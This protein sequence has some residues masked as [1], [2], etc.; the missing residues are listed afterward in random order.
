MTGLTITICGCGNGAHA[1]AA[2]MSLKGHRVNVFSPLEDEI[3]S[4][5][6]AYS[7]NGGLT[8][9]FG[10]GLLSGLDALDEGALA[11]IETY[12][13]LRL[14]KIS[15]NP[16]E[17]IPQASLI[18]VIVPAFAHKNILKSIAPHLSRDSLLVFLPSRGGLELELKSIVPEARVMAFQTL[19]W[20]TR[21][22]KFG[23]EILISARKNSILA[24]ARPMDLSELFFAQLEHLLDMEI[25]PVKH[26]ATLTFSNI[27]QI[28]HPGIMYSIFK[29]NPTER[30]AADKLPFFYQ[31]IDEE[32]GNRLSCMSEELIKIAGVAG[33]INSDIETN[34]VLH[35][36]DWL[37]TS[38][39]GLIADES[40]VCRMIV[41][42]KAYDGLRAPV[43][44]L[45]DGLYTPD[46]GTRYITED[47]P[48]GLL[49]SKS[50]AIMGGVDT[51][52]IDEVLSGIDRWTGLDYL[53]RLNVLKSI[54]ASSRL[55]ELYGIDTLEDLLNGG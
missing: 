10:A 49:I 34:R 43:R 39:E 50:I 19:P 32:G 48:Y 2:L 37:K 53:G 51:P 11:Q 15:S 17:V 52:T 7:E 24:A 47:V 8:M 44:K 26:M 55:P 31:A 30:F 41:T 9:R 22:H 27:G 38:Y 20:A 40:S 46:F 1:C 28:V 12:E 36:R 42:N 3:S 29:K 33:H 23:K 16:Q 54:K 18:F 35:I 21:I 13:D 25:V 45:E 4:F 6:N 14:E 5:Q